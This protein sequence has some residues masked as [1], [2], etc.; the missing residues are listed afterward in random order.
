M[1]GLVAAVFFK[2]YRCYKFVIKDILEPRKT[3][4]HSGMGNSSTTCWA[5]SFVFDSMIRLSVIP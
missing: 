2:K 4:M 3:S 5:L 1:T